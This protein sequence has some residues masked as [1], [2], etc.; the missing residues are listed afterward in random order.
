MDYMEDVLPQ[1]VDYRGISTHSAAYWN[2]GTRKP[3]SAR[4]SDGSRSQQPFRRNPTSVGKTHTKI[5]R[6]TTR[7]RRAP[8]RNRLIVIAL[9]AVIGIAASACLIPKA[10][11]IASSLNQNAHAC[12]AKLTN[13]GVSTP[14]SDWQKGSMP[15][16]YQTDD[17]WADASYAGSTIGEA[18]CGPTALS[19]VY[20]ELTGKQNLGPKKLA[21]WSEEH[22]YIESGA[23]RWAL[24]SEGAQ[25]LGLHAVELNDIDEQTVTGYLDAEQPIICIMGPGDFTDSGHFIVLWKNQ[26]NGTVEIRDPNSPANSHADWELSLILSQCR[27]LWTYT[28]A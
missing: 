6:P 18:G 12:V 22:G 28:V 11:K 26:S 14:K 20:I 24:M 23:T 13:N 8:H 7:T 5:K 27:C 19:M 1:T 21:R 10:A 3:P 9:I 15:Y 2:S 17:A 16:L 4:A 25:S